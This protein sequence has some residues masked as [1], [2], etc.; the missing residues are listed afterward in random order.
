MLYTAGNHDVVSGEFLAI[1]PGSFTGASGVQNT[2]LHM[3]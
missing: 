3:F 1:G 2:I